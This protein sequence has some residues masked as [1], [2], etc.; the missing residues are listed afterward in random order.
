MD[1]HLLPVL[2]LHVGIRGVAEEEGT[3]IRTTLEKTAIERNIQSGGT[4]I[5]RGEKRLMSAKFFNVGNLVKHREDSWSVGIIIAVDSHN[6]RKKAK[7]RASARNA[8]TYPY[9]V[10][11]LILSSNLRSWLGM[12]NSAS[13]ARHDKSSLRKI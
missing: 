6:L 12:W 10:L 4:N 9:T 8:R 13:W 5:G 1:V 7:D 11:W 3:R 2:E